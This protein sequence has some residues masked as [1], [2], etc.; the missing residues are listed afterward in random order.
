MY[1]RH[2]TVT[3]NGKTHTYWR[4][5]RTV[6][7]GR[8][9]RQE[10]VAQ[11]GELDAKGR[12]A[13]HHLADSLV[14]VDR[15]PGLFDEE[16]PTAPVTVVPSRLR[17]ERGRRF[18]DVWL[19]W[20]LWQALGL[21]TWLEK[22]LA[23]GR[24]DVPRFLTLFESLVNG[25]ACQ[26]VTLT[27]GIRLLSR[28]VKVPGVEYRQSDPPAHAFPRPEDLAR[29]D[30]QSLQPLG[31]S[32]QKA[33]ALIELA[34]AASE[35]CLDLERLA[36]EPDE[37]IRDRLCG[38]RGVG[39]WTAEY[40][41]LRSLGRLHIFPGDDVGARN[42]LRRWLGLTEPLGYEAVRRVLAAGGPALGSSNQAVVAAQ[43]VLPKT[44]IRSV[45]MQAS[46]DF[47]KIAPEGLKAMGY[48]EAYVRRC[49]LEPS[50]LEL[51][52]TRTSQL[53]GCAYCID[54]HTKDA[55]ARGETEQRLYALALA[56]NPVFHRARAR[57]AGLDRNS[58]RGGPQPRSGRRVPPG[59]PAFQREGVGR[60]DAGRRHHQWLEPARD[61]LPRGARHLSAPRR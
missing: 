32:H 29:L 49:G 39:R 42:N 43:I 34:R 15:Q 2:S 46:V 61:Q 59:S 52:K 24:E 54:T 37:I 28:L 38:L 58:D 23:R 20:K 53:N 12:I 40:V 31:F 22:R 30:W 44:I 47:E 1:Q 41:L 45:I 19:A 57:G 10:T 7:V 13:A 55:R 27:L 6:R 17:L 8:K 11:L 26:Q 25:I 5:V 3:K 9:V 50:L 60:S 48:L 14:G 4:L 36:H 56:R 16:L 33:Q 18:G 51:V 21:D 35:G